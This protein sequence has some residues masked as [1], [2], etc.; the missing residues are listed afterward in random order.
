MQFAG[1]KT[2]EFSNEIKFLKL[3]SEE[4]LVITLNTLPCGVSAFSLLFL[5]V[6]TNEDDPRNKEKHIPGESHLI[7]HF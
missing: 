3:F 1:M 7:S 4:M 2:C 6:E 5:N